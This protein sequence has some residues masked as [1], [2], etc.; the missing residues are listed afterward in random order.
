MI[1]CC[2]AERT[3]RMN[4]ITLTAG[5]HHH[6]SRNAAPGVQVG[7][8]FDIHDRCSSQPLRSA[9]IDFDSRRNRASIAACPH[10]TRL[11]HERICLELSTWVQVWDQPICRGRKVIKTSTA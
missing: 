1:S 8:T 5:I 7:L 11:Y 10:A 3:K 9:R 4:T 2:A 6:L